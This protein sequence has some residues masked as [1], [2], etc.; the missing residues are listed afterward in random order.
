LRPLEWPP[1]T[2]I[3]CEDPGAECRLVI[4]TAPRWRITALLW[5]QLREA[6]RCEWKLPTGEEREGGGQSEAAMWKG[7]AV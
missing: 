6:R 7:A 2:V 3:T 4:T 5:D 1:L